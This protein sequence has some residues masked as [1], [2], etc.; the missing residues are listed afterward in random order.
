MQEAVVEDEE[1]HETLVLRRRRQRGMVVDAQI[2]PV[3]ED[4]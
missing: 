2:A 4:G 1:R 3:P